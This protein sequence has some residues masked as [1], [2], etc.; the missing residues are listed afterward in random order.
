MRLSNGI[1]AELSKITG[2]AKSRL[3]DY[4]A[5]RVR[6]RPERARDLES[7]CKLA[8]FN[9]PAAIW[10]LGSSDEIKNSLSSSYKNRAINK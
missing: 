3:C 6:P 1:L 9:C 2:I 7:A 5:A 10:L 4:T 8:G